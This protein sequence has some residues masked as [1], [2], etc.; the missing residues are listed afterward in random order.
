MWLLLP[1]R[2]LKGMIKLAVLNAPCVIDR[3]WQ[4]AKAERF[5]GNTFDQHLLLLTLTA[6]IR[7]LRGVLVVMACLEVQIS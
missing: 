7:V 2:Y 3:G 1:L 5:R 4:Q 6:L